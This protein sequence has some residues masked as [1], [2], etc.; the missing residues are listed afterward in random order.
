[1]THP[2]GGY[3]QNEYWDACAFLEGLGMEFWS[4]SIAV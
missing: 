1:M 4:S 2:R 3:F